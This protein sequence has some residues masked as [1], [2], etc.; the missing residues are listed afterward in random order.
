MAISVAMGANTIRAHTLGVSTGHS[1]SL[2]PSKG[3]VNTDAFDAI[4]YAIF[5]ARNYGLRLI[6]PLTDEYQYY[7]VC[8]LLSHLPQNGVRLTTCTRAGWQVRLYQVGRRGH[9]QRLRLLHVF[10]LP[11][12]VQRVHLCAPEPR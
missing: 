3:V 10:N 5:A 2:M 11:D 6:I 1:L 12:P 8:P 9:E 7:H 4:D